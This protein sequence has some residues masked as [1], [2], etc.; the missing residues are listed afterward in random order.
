MHPYALAILVHAWNCE[1]FAGNA[2]F[3]SKHFRQLLQTGQ[4]PH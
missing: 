3:G 2:E 4:G 1:Y